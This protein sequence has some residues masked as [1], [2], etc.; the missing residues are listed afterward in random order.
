MRKKIW[1]FLCR[2][3]FLFFILIS[4][5]LAKETTVDTKTDIWLAREAMRQILYEQIRDFKKHHFV[6]LL[7][8][9]RVLYVQSLLL[10]KYP[11]LFPTRTSFHDDGLTKY[12]WWDIAY[13]HKI[14]K[15]KDLKVIITSDFLTT[16]DDVEY[17]R[18]MVH[19][20]LYKL[21]KAY[22]KQFQKPLNLNSA[23]RSYFYQQN[24]FNKQCFEEK[25][26]A[27]PWTSEH[28]NGYTIDISHIYH[29]EYQRMQ[30]HAHTYGFHQ[31]YQKESDGLQIEPRH[32]RYL[33]IGLATYLHD[34]QMSFKD[35]YVWWNTE[36]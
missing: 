22:Y 33:W 9:K 2:S 31:S 16:T 25:I 26:C 3:V 32:R 8:K 17:L 34:H 27:F 36:S 11:W 30:K 13:T 1:Y 7:T 6:P 10:E 35:W 12:V 20:P 14:Y 5:S 29:D 28:Q 24:H 18:E 15:P 21:A 19:E 23:W 4:F